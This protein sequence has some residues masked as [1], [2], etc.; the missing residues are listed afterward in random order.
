MNSLMS[1]LIRENTS[2][3][4]T[5]SHALAASGSRGSRVKSMTI[6]QSVDSIKTASNTQPKSEVA[7]GL[8]NPVMNF[9]LW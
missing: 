2:Q 1:C 3:K 8:I 9:S 6:R 5:V 4:A 7:Q